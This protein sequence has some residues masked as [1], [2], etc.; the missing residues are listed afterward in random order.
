MQSPVT[1]EIDTLNDLYSLYM[2]FLVNGGLFYPS[3]EEYSL[4]TKMRLSV[5]L[6][7][8]LDSVDT[9]VT[10]A[11]VSPNSNQSNKPQGVGLAFAEQDSGLRDTIEK[12]LA[13]KLN[14][15][16]PTFTM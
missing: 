8:A 2:P 14:S 6:P 16:E 9:E 4:G 11:W 10:V 15:S 3:R 7:D 1:L 13:S 12:L 5:L